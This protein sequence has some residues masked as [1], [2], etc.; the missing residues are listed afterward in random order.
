MEFIE[1]LVNFFTT[2]GVVVAFFVLIRGFYEYKHKIAL[3][4][5]N[6]FLQMRT[7]F[8]ETEPYCKI[9]PL[10][11]ATERKKKESKEKLENL[12]ARE[13]Y[14]FVGFFEEL[15]LMMNSKLIP[16]K[17]VFYFFGYYI[18]LTRK[19]TKYFLSN[20]ELKDPLWS[21][22]VDLSDEMRKIGRSY[23]YKRKEIRFGTPLY[24]S[25]RL[26]K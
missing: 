2:A 11:N 3:E 26:L 22:F 16:K 6:K 14:D 17:V 25:F 4:C 10:M 21:V 24:K 9:Y 5:A 18:L 7:K 8:K 13:I 20:E 12:K 1:L 23:K 19:M 15:A